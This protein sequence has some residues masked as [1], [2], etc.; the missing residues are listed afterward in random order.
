MNFFARFSLLAAIALAG[1]GAAIVM[2]IP[3]SDYSTGRAAEVVQPVPFSHKHHVQGL[4]LDC[5]FCH[6]SVETS[7]EAGLPDTHTCM[8]CHSQVWTQAAMLAPVRDSESENR[9][10]HWI[11]V[12]NLPDHVYFDHHA[13]VRQGV[14]CA[15]CHGDVANMASVVQV[16]SFRMKD[17]IDCHEAPGDHGV[18]PV[19][20]RLARP[21]NLRDCFLCHR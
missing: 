4:G 6:A 10:L 1:L 14:A 16:R 2:A 19:E 21:L 9:R 5:R 17:C 12:H 13:H 7:A 11:R 15:V 18:M 20:G 8:G 3:Q